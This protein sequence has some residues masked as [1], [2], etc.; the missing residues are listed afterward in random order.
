MEREVDDPT[1]TLPGT[2][3][4]PPKCALADLWKTAQSKAD[5]PSDAVAS[6][7]YDADGYTF[8]ISAL[9]IYLSFDVECRLTG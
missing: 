5:A 9:R 4:A 7:D 8:S 6:I 1:T 2:I 3:A